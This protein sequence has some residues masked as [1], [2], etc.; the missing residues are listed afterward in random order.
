MENYAR[1]DSHF[2][3]A[4]YDKMARAAMRCGNEM[5]IM[6]FGKPNGKTVNKIMHI[7]QEVIFYLMLLL[8]F[9]FSHF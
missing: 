7:V 3:L 2:L 1:L 9:F 4:I 5:G 8:T 6:Q